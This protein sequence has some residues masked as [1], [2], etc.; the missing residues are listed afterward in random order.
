MSLKQSRRLATKKIA[1]ESEA[2]L[3]AHIATLD[4]LGHVNALKAQMASEGIPVKKSVRR[5]LET[6]KQDIKREQEEDVVSP[7]ELA[8]KKRAIR[9]AAVRRGLGPRVNS[10]LFFGPGTRRNSRGRRAIKVADER[11]L[12]AALEA[13]NAEFQERNAAVVAA[14]PVA[15]AAPNAM[16]SLARR[17]ATMSLGP[18]AASNGRHPWNRERPRMGVPEYHDNWGGEERD[19][20]GGARRKKRKTRRTRRKGRGRSRR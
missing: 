15:A 12:N 14:A 18:R 8:K 19:K 7:S 9:R 1:N 11:N 10:G 6:R 16:N 5:A 20:E 2:A 17:F 3:L 4:T 13:L